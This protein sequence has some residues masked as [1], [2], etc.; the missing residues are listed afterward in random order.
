LCGQY[1]GY[2]VHRAHHIL[3]YFVTPAASHELQEFTGLQ[4]SPGCTSGAPVYAAHDGAV[5]VVIHVCSFESEAIA[6]LEANKF[7]GL[8]PSNVFLVHQHAMP[9]FHYVDKHSLEEDS[10]S[11]LR[12]YG[13][14]FAMQQ[15]SWP[16]EAVCFDEIGKRKILQESLIDYMKVKKIEWMVSR[17]V[18]D[19]SNF[20]IG[21]FINMDKFACMLRC[22]SDFGAAMGVELRQSSNISDI[23]KFSSVALAK[24]DADSLVGAEP[25]HKCM[26]EINYDSCRS[27]KMITLLEQLG[28]QK[29]LYSGCDRYFYSFNALA[30]TMSEQRITPT[31]YLEDWEGADGI[32][33]DLALYPFFD[34]ADISHSPKMHA[35]GITG[36][37]PPP[38]KL[39]STEGIQ[40]MLECTYKQDRHPDFAEYIQKMGSDKK[41]GPKR[42]I[43]RHSL[44]A[45]VRLKVVVFCSNDANQAS[46]QAVRLVQALLRPGQDCLYLVTIVNEGSEIPTGDKLLM[47][48]EGS[49]IKLSTHRVVLLKNA[50]QSYA[51]IMND[52]VETSQA[53][54][55]AVGS[56]QLCLGS[57]LG[58]VALALAKMCKRPLIVHKASA[59]MP[60]DLRLAWPVVSGITVSA[61]KVL[62]FLSQL[63]READYTYLVRSTPKSADLT[64]VQASQRVLSQIEQIAMA[65]GLHPNP[66]HFTDMKAR[67]ALLK[68]ARE[69]KAQMLAVEIPKHIDMTD[70]VQSILLDSPCSVLIFREVP[71]HMQRTDKLD[72]P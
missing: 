64:E 22:Q 50:D 43:K 15:L 71:A 66:K 36:D 13:T 53:D 35:V 29:M 27:L 49:D 8:D 52:Y 5:Q 70:A 65:K 2:R 47:S 59:R 69:Q 32:F 20:Q 51:E 41:G 28:A 45:M 40:R 56:E 67:E 14:G 33:E 24:A 48:F 46:F 31:L 42:R 9:G 1:T 11:P 68:V 60:K 17:R 3:A 44:G 16:R 21:E 26:C 7:F 39:R 19:L 30:T 61:H 54:L 10:R 57:S 18:N 55:V 34:M 23:H 6:E 62:V 63:L 38:P 37:S 58:S 12:M 25:S 4:G 72:V